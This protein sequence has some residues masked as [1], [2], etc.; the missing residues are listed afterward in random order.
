[1]VEKI[2]TQEVKVDLLILQTKMYCDAYE[3]TC[4]GESSSESEDGAVGCCINIFNIF[5]H[6]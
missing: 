4:R 5:S 3:T 6:I 1:M 2:D